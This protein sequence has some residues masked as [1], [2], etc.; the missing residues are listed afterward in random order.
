MNN[1]CGLG[2]CFT[3]NDPSLPYVCLCPNAQFAMS[4]EDSFKYPSTT[5]RMLIQTPPPPPPLPT[6][7]SLEYYCNPLDL[8]SCMHGGQCLPLMN[9]YRCLCLP[10][11]TG[12]YC[13]ISKN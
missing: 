13:E 7:N 4:C 9:G 12:R 2:K 3:I 10:G 11:Y 5:A 6:T 8:N 1:I